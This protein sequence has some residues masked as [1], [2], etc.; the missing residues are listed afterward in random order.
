MQKNSFNRNQTSLIFIVSKRCFDHFLKFCR[1]TSLSVAHCLT[2]YYSLGFLTLMI[3]VY[4]EF[5]E[6]ADRIALST[7]GLDLS[8][9][10][11]CL[12]TTNPTLST[13]TL[14]LSTNLTLLSTR[15]ILLS[16]Q[17]NLFNLPPYKI[18]YNSFTPHQ[19]LLNICLLY[20]K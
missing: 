12:S 4:W 5:E 2:K 18:F 13:H 15:K 7:P 17:P 8:T 10:Y 9:D 1:S 11:V 19:Y 6:L 16:T 3:F 20:L 14:T